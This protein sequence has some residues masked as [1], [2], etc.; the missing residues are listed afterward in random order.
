[1]AIVMQLTRNLV[2]SFCTFNVALQFFLWG[3]GGGGWV[4][5]GGW[6]ELPGWDCGG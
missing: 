6:V 1:M 2:S 3:G 5:L 4:G